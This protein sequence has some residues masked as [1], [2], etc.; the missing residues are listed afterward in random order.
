MA[1][2]KAM[3]LMSQKARAIMPSRTGIKFLPV[4]LRALIARIVALMR[5]YSAEIKRIQVGKRRK[6]EYPYW[7]NKYQDKTKLTRPNN[8]L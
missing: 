2:A 3:P 7:L 1:E 8:N 6:A 5:K 4:N